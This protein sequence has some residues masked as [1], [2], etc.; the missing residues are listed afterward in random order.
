MTLLSVC[1]K[2]SHSVLMP[3]HYP[4]QPNGHSQPAQI[5][6]RSFEKFRCCYIF[7]TNN[8]IRK[9][10]PLNIFY[11]EYLTKIIR[12]ENNTS[13]RW[14]FI[15]EP[16]DIRNLFTLNN[17]YVATLWGSLL[18]ASSSLTMLHD[19]RVVLFQIFVA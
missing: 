14:S 13:A 19:L 18:L 10:R 6:Y 15:L 12:L 4:M 8:N 16:A 17:L 1:T 9:F 2:M 7:C 3:F 5:N 11:T